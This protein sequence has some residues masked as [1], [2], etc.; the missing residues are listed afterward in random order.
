M[1]GM[2]LIYILPKTIRTLNPSFF[3]M[4]CSTKAENYRIYMLKNFVEIVQQEVDHCLYENIDRDV[5]GELSYVFRY[6]FRGVKVKGLLLGKDIII[7]E[8]QKF[9]FEK[10]GLQPS[11]IRETDIFIKA[12]QFTRLVR[13]YLYENGA[14]PVPDNLWRPI[15]TA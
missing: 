7:N 10:Y 8:N 15:L 2:I 9:I 5:D 4:Y 14:Y 12:G 11:G 3:L 1:K 6:I 13:M